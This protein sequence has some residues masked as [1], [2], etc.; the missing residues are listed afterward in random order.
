MKNGLIFGVLA[1]ITCM[2]WVIF[3]SNTFPNLV[4]GSLSS[5]SIT[6]L[7]AILFMVLACQK[8]KTV[9]NGSIRFGEAFLVCMT[10]FAAF[11]FVYT[12]GFKS[13]LDLSPESMDTFLEITKQSTA[14]LLKK[15]GASEDDI[16][17]S[18]EELDETLQ[19]AMTWQTTLLNYVVSLVFPG[20]ILSLIVAG[21]TSQF[22][23]T[24]TQV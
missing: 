16:F 17:K 3:F 10:T 13:Y 21:I 11:M 20:A 19:M 8:E 4:Y 2:A 15:M 1:G 24:P 18:I 7:V 12:I 9:L 6:S 23:K 14:D 5:M 22:S